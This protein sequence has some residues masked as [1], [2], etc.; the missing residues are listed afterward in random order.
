MNLGS[1]GGEENDGDGD[2]SINKHGMEHTE[3]N[4]EDPYGDEV[5]NHPTTKPKNGS[6][7]ITKKNKS[8]VKRCP[9][10]VKKVKHKKRLVVKRID[11]ITTTRHATR[12]TNHCTKWS[13]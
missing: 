8:I 1:K 12:K 9:S 13:K 10:L 3:E 4:L 5:A 11:N 6:I 2:E 7:V